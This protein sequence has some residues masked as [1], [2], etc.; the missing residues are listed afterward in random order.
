MLG[1]LVTMTTRHLKTGDKIRL[2]DLGITP[3]SGSEAARMGRNPATGEAMPIKA[4]K[5]IA[6]RPAKELKEAVWAT[7]GA[8]KEGGELP[9]GAAGHTAV[10]RK[11]TGV[12][13]LVSFGCKHLVCAAW[14]KI[15]ISVPRKPAQKCPEAEPIAR[16][17][18]DVIVYDKGCRIGDK[19]TLDDLARTTD[20]GD[21]KMSAF[22]TAR[23]PMQWPRVGW[24]WRVTA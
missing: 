9:D 24:L 8:D 15:S 7:T 13:V 19:L 12:S 1:D 22:E 21:W 20:I 17:L 2:T 23:R 16:K 10:S 14:V 3:G 11:A 18:L 4:S 6:F 5:K